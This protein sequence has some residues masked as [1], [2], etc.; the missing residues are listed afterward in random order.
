M[1]SISSYNF[2]LLIIFLL[3]SFIGVA[4]LPFVPVQLQPTSRQQS[5]SVGFSW[6]N[7]SPL[8]VEQEVTSLLEGAL[9]S[10]KGVA[11]I[12]SESSNGRGNINLSFAEGVDMDIARFEVA[13]IIRNHFQSLPEGVSYP[14]VYQGGQKASDRPV[15]VYAVLSPPGY[16]N[17]PRLIDEKVIKHMIA[18]E[19]VENAEMYG[20][21]PMFWNVVYDAVKMES[22][23]L[24]ENSL[25]N[26]IST[27]QMRYPIGQTQVKEDGKDMEMGVVIESPY[28]RQINW[29]QLPLTKNGAKLVK[30]GDIAS[31]TLEESQPTS[32]YRVNGLNTNVLV[33]YAREGENQLALVNRL[34][35][36]AATIEAAL[37]QDI[38]LL[39]VSD[40]TE[41]VKKEIYNIAWRTALTLLILLT[42]V[43]L[44]SRSWKYL[45]I[46]LASLVANLCIAFILYYI[47]AIEIHLYSIAGITVSFGLL[48]DNSI[49]MIDHVRLKHNLKVF[50]A[51]LASTLTTMAAL[52][53]VFFLS[54]NLQNNLLDFVKIVI[55]NLWVSLFVALFFIPSLMHRMNFIK[56]TGLKK[57]KIKPKRRAVRFT[58]SYSKII[59][60]LLCYK[61]AALTITILSFGLPMFLLPHEIDKEGFWPHIYN[62]TFGSKFYN[63][64]LRTPLNNLLGGTLRLF[65][66]KADSRNYFTEKSETT[67][68]VNIFM[69]D[70]ASINHMNEVVIR[71][72]NYLKQYSEIKQ[73]EARIQNANSAGI[74]INFTTSAELSG[75]PFYLKEQLTAFAITLGSADCQ[76]F[77][78]GDGFSNVMKEQ[79]GSF[80]V[81]FQGYNYDQVYGYAQ[82]LKDSLLANSRVKEVNITEKDSWYR[83]NSKEF[84]L[85]TSQEM[86]A[87]HNSFMSGFYLDLRTMSAKNS[88]AGTVVS[89]GEKKQ[90]FMTSSYQ[91]DFNRWNLNH[92]MVSYG[93]RLTRIG[94]LGKVVKE[95]TAGAIVKRNQN[96]QLFLEY[97]FIGP[98]QLGQTHLDERMTEVKEE[99]PMGFEAEQ[100]N[101][102]WLSA[103]EITEQ[104]LSLLVIILLIFFICSILFESLRQ[105]LAILMIIPFSFIGLFLTYY[106]LD[107]GFNQGGY[108]AMILLSGLT[109]NSTIYIINEIN[110]L[111]HSHCGSKL[112]L[113]LKAFNTKILPIILTIISTVLGLVPFL[114]DGNLDKFWNALVT[115]TIG[116]LLFS[117]LAIY[118]YLPLFLIKKKDLVVK[119]TLAKAQK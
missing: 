108:A 18:M 45:L 16:A 11:S 98:H 93:G 117:V 38:S 23:G 118:F 55:I 70:G 76:I 62:S 34:K 39:L 15:L 3:L 90:V 85:A 77:G 105:P 48:I 12:T 116:G 66:E 14:S 47:F 88:D 94:E 6:A 72:E 25:K 95:K 30:M 43:F 81:R 31:V 36:E 2:T 111:K 64:T 54:E 9:N 19:G 67:L 7:A 29:Q 107:I 40:P 84:T 83:E 73:F 80:K 110:N 57:G 86:L 106:L 4:I 32:Y 79:S 44:V 1:R 104:N 49:I 42:F 69:P 41:F 63:E 24:T 10:L 109:V 27:S 50:L 26:A 68:Q 71:L 58:R 35:A 75:F 97:E 91:D 114:I 89:H 112:R 102:S 8:A 78:V 52:G 103:N 82:W 33:I 92:D 5:I 28:L 65:V 46:I 59:R 53:V 119:G 101:R 113:Y 61:I 37:P 13:T 74:G 96:Y 56:S 99:L 17:L 100:L 51:I 115:G 60:F 22:L 21:Y 20:V 87:V